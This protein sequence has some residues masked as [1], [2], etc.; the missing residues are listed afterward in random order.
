[1]NA[2]LGRRGSAT[3]FL[4]VTAGIALSG[5]G[6]DRLRAVSRRPTVLVGADATCRPAALAHID[7]PSACRVQLVARNG[8]GEVVS[9]SGWIE[10]GGAR[11]RFDLPSHFDW[12]VLEVD[13]G[14]DRSLGAIRYETEAAVCTPPGAPAD[15]SIASR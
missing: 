6:A 2:L 9:S 15:R 1:M 8:A 4:L 12:V 5:C 10:A 11:P 14:C 13:P 7:N 3:A